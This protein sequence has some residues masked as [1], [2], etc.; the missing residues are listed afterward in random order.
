MPENSEDDD[1]S[2]EVYWDAVR[3]SPVGD[4]DPT[5]VRFRDLAESGDLVIGTS[6]DRVLVIIKPNGE[7][8]FGPEYSP[9]EASVIFWEHM[10]R[11]RAVVEE[12]FLIIQH[13][14]AILV[15][16]GQQDMECERI[17]LAAADE[18]DPIRKAGLTQMADLAMSRL[19]MVAN[20]AIELG[21]GLV[22]RPEV[23]VPEVPPGVPPS[24]QSNPAS[25]YQGREGLPEEG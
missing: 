20:Q 8:I 16:L 3:R 22:R 14:E 25:D 19:S 17:R 12:R 5:V 23:A 13:M 10:A 2:L 4:P 21:R 7:M 24:I 18:P 9:T 15:R 1:L 6:R 11:Q